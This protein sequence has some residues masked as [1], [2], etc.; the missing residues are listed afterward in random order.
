MQTKELRAFFS[1]SVS[2]AG[3][4]TDI[5]TLE[6]GNQIDTACVIK[7]DFPCITSSDIVAMID[8]LRNCLHLV[9]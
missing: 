2:H 6:M 4:N 3:D 8:E 9:S 1:A 5:L 7:I